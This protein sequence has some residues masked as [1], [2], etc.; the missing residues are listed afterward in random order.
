MTA[1]NETYVPVRCVYSIHGWAGGYHR[2]AGTASEARL[3]R[4]AAATGL[5]RKQ[6][7]LQ[8]EADPIPPSNIPD[9]PPPSPGPPGTTR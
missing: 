9:T 7:I 6:R 5:S 2:F 1:N 3:S 4:A 8:A